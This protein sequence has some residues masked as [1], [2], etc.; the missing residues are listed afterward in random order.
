MHAKN[1]HREEGPL[2]L[3]PTATSPSST[4]PTRRCTAAQHPLSTACVS[5]TSNSQ[6]PGRA[7][8]RRERGDEREGPS[9]LGWKGVPF[10]S[11]PHSRGLCPGR[12]LMEAES[13]G[14]YA[15]S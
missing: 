8:A 11:S 13:S 2:L 6:M 4:D 9:E 7:M 1:A 10:A 3:L 14:L 12:R 5:T 15:Y